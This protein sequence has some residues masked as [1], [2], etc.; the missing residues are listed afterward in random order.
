MPSRPQDKP[1]ETVIATRVWDLP[2]RLFHW[3]LAVAVIGLIVTAKVGGNAMEVH[4]LL[5][6][7]VLAMLVFRLVWGFVGGYWSRFARFFYT[8]K[9]VFAYLRGQSRPDQFHDV[10][11]SPLASFSVYGLL[12]VLIAQVGS[13]LF[14]DDEI[15]SAGPLARFVE[16]QTSGRLTAWHTQ[17]GQWLVIGLVVLHVLA[18]LYYVFVKRKTLVAPMVTGDKALPA[19]VPSAADTWKT[20]ITAFVLFA[21]AAGLAAWVAGLRA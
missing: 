2:T 8:P 4:F 5:G 18:I 12:L 15:A 3:L 14:A 19:G 7:A 9:T 20:R 21:L 16:A 13:G 6:Y 10:G 17:Y 1:P 11:H